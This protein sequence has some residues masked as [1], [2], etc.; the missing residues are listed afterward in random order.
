MTEGVEV[1]DRK[2]FSAGVRFH[3]RHDGRVIGAVAFGA[4]EEFPGTPGTKLDVAYRLTENEWNG[5]IAPELKIV[6]AR[7][8][9][10]V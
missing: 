2:P 7:P 9:A 4:N 5:T 3:F 6:D 10:A 1:C 8:A